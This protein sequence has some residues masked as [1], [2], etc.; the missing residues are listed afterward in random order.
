MTNDVDFNGCNVSYSHHSCFV[1]VVYFYLQIL[2]D[3]FNF[4]RSS[5]QEAFTNIY[6]RRQV[7]PLSLFMTIF[8]L[9]SPFLSIK[10]RTM[11]FAIDLGFFNKI[12]RK[13]GKVDERTQPHA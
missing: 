3:D 1:F 9:F 4:F 10:K 2:F 8:L 6:L 11:T 12:M 7:T 5:E 13:E